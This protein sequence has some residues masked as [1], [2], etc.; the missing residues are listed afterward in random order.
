[1]G[2][3]GQTGWESALGNIE[4]GSVQ[5]RISQIFCNQGKVRDVGQ[6]YLNSEEEGGFPIQGLLLFASE[7]GAGDVSVRRPLKCSIQKNTIQLSRQ[8]KSCN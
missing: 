7:V 4:Q 1:M 6:Q 8:R 2:N 3:G 5:K